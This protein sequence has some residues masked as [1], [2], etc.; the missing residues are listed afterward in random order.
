MLSVITDVSPLAK[1]KDQSPF[2]LPSKCVVKA[3]AA[4]KLQ[5]IN[6]Q[7]KRTKNIVKIVVNK[8][9]CENSWDKR[10]IACIIF[11]MV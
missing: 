7:N 4:Q 11:S 3:V 6:I 9:Q 5:E 8:N 2:L 1:H 10:S